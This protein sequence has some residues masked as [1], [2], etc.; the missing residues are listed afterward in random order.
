M[1]VF[2]DALGCPKALVDAERICYFLQDG[3]HEIVF[4]PENADAIVVNSCGF[5]E[6]AKQES[7]DAVL[8]YAQL[9]KNNPRLKLILS[10]CLSER[11]KGEISK[12]IPE[13]DSII[14]VRDQS[15]IVETLTSPSGIPVDSG[16][17]NDISYSRERALFFSGNHT[18]YIKIAEG[19]DRNCGFCAIPGIRGRH[20]SRTME[21]ILDEALYLSGQGARELIVVSEDTLA[22]GTDLYGK[23]SLVQLLEK[24]SEVNVDWIRVMYFFPEP[25]ALEVVRFMKGNPKFC[26]YVDIPFQH[27]GAA[28][29]KSMLRPGGLIEYQRLLDSMRSINPGLAF[30]T[31]FIIGFPGETREDI[32]NLGS[33][34]RNN[35]FSRVGFFEYSRE[36]G[37]PAYNLGKGADSRTVSK[38]IM[39]LASIQEEC[40]AEVLSRHVGT[41]MKVLSEGRTEDREGE[42]VHLYRSEYDAPEIDGLV[43]VNGPVGDEPF[44]NVKI[45]GVSAPHDLAGIPVTV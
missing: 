24:L 9:K 1:K 22:Y 30:R 13:V 42:T 39:E 17:F 37:T 34:I 40:S 7:I 41:V 43:Y 11:Y 15:R 18:A 45:T 14:G 33:F 31:S 10:G 36:E 2:V 29:L 21:S 32:K 12:L 25:Y 8:K 38:R 6:K 28:V 19:C 26:R 20:R 44:I 35:G 5:I 16:E 4:N 23:K 27:T 3:R